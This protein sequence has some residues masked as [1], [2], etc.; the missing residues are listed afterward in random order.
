M[1]GKQ[2]GSFGHLIGTV[3]L[4]WCGLGFILMGAVFVIPRYSRPAIESDEKGLRLLN[5]KNPR[6]RWKDLSLVVLEPLPENP[7]LVK[8]VIHAVSQ[9]KGSVP[10]RPWEIILERI[11][12]LPQL[13]QDLKPR[14][15]ET[16]TFSV[17]KLDKPSLSGTGERHGFRVRWL[18]CYMAG[19]WLLLHAMPLIIVGIAYGKSTRPRDEDVG[20]PP[21]AFVRFVLKHFRSPHQ[22]RHAILE[23]GTGLGVA[24]LILLVAG[25]RGLSREGKRTADSA[26]AALE[27]IKSLPGST[28]LP[29]TGARNG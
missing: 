8:V 18:Y 19:M 24:G 13:L 15:L 27:R 29:A 3:V 1:E 11:G 12:Q 28:L 5:R 16:P 4:G 26:R 20:P 23:A 17:R 10:I 14:H 25:E 9:G 21:K 6:V 2:V 7:D 22:I